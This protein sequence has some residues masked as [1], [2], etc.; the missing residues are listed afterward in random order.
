MA[1]ARPLRLIARG[2]AAIAIALA[3][4]LF[5]VSLIRPPP[6]PSLQPAFDAAEAQPMM[7]RTRIARDPDRQAFFGDLH[8]HSA[9][10]PDA[11][12][13]GVRAMPSDAYRYAKGATIEHGAGYPIRISRPLDFAAV[14]DHSEYLGVVRA[15]GEQ[16]TLGQRSLRERL[17][18]DGKLSLSVAYFTAVSELPP[19]TQ[20]TVTPPEGLEQVPVD[21]WRTLIDAAEAHNEPGVFT[22]FIAYE[23]SG[24]SRD[25]GHLHRNVIY[26]SNR[27]PER[28]FSAVDSLKPRD[29]WQALDEQRTLGMPVLAIPHNP[30]LSNG[31]AFD[32]VDKDGNPFDAAYVARRRRNE[33]LAE[34]FQVKGTSETHPVLS[35]AD[36]FA[37]F[38]ISEGFI[39]DLP[40]GIDRRGSY[41]RAAWRRGLEMA[42]TRGFDPFDFGVIGSSDGHGASSPVEEDSFHG[43]LPMLDGS[44]GIRLGVATFVPRA[45]APA[46]RWG[47]AGLA[48]IWAEENTRAS[49]FAA[50]RRKETFATSGPRMR[51]RMFGGWNFGPTDLERADA[52]RH[53]YANGVPMGGTLPGANGTASPGFLVWAV[54]DADGANLDRLQI[55]KAW[56]EADGTSAEKVF[57]I[58]A[59]D[60]RT[61]DAEGALAPLPSTVDLTTARYTNEFGAGELSAFWSDPEFD[62]ALRALY[63]ARV[64]EIPTPRWSTYDAV[65]LGVEPPEPH[66]LQERAVASPIWYTPPP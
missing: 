37:D 61:P 1:P 20:G 47:A 12:V 52:I 25:N 38:E 2:L 9:L 59:S 64:I 7:E 43:K 40:Q 8:I 18:N 63:Y 5:A 65:Q 41:A 29:L 35:S 45:A 53:A 26:A 36:E 4:A 50:M 15:Q 32:V 62:P 54:K 58:A 46:S 39:G 56:V 57:E 51:V 17:L 19:F 21:A 34:I 30:N 42:Q 24:P 44:A 27:V 14:T 60:A 10:S 11:Y 48:G 33:P 66:T 55:V 28:P 3:I 13:F 31:D 6:D 49:L 16:T 23:W 22:T